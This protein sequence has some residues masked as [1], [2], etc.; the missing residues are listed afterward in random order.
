MP[1]EQLGG[2]PLMLGLASLS[3]V[4]QTI[5]LLL[6]Q[7]RCC[8]NPQRYRQV[9]SRPFFADLRWRKVHCDPRSGWPLEAA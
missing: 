7:R 9:K 1:I 2:Q 4:Y 3:I 5:G 8:N 6:F